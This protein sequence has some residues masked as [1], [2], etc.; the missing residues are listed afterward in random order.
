MTDKAATGWLVKKAEVA[1]NGASLLDAAS[2]AGV[3]S[4][5]S[6]PIRLLQAL[7]LGLFNSVFSVLLSTNSF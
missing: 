6:H 4:Q 3:D 7:R 2:T 5:V 1:T